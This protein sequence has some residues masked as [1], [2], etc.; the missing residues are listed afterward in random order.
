EAPAATGEA[1]APAATDAPSPAVTEAPATPSTFTVSGTV[2]NIP[3]G[4]HTTVTLTGPGGSVTATVDGSGHYAMSGLPAGH[5][6]VQCSWETDAGAAQVG[7]VGSVD[8]NGDSDVS[9]ALP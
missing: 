9:F 2:S 5:Y 4:V 1:P 8:V 7:K 3:Q 6:D